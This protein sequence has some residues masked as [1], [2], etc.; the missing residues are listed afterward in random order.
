MN[1][2][3]PFNLN[4]T[5]DLVGLF[6]FSPLR[7]CSPGLEVMISYLPSQSPVTA[8]QVHT[9]KSGLQTL[10]IFLGD[11]GGSSGDRTWSLHNELHPSTFCFLL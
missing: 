1:C 8:L 6:F 2:K 7:L 11:G 9:T 10:C 3:F 4:K 5:R